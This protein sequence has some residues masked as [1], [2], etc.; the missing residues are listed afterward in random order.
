MSPYLPRM[1]GV[2]GPFVLSQDITP[3]YDHDISVMRLVVR[4]EDLSRVKDI[5]SRHAAAIVSELF[6]DVGRSRSSRRSPGRSRYV[7]DEY[8]GFRLAR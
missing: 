7:A 8:F 5:V 2:I 6:R 1:M 3:G 4:R